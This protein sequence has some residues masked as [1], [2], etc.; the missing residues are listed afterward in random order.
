MS[1]FFEGYS[2]PRNKELMRIFR[3][4]DMVEY[5]GSGIPR[6][7]KAYPKESFRFTENFTRMIFPSA[8]PA[9]TEA[10]QKGAVESAVKS[11]VETTQ[12]TSG[13]IIQAIRNNN[14][15]TIPEMAEQFGI[16]ERSIE[17]NIQKLRESGRLLRKEGA[18]GGH[19]EILNQ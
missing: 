12:K 19:W 9:P 7:L 4:L 14:H 17:R 8:E 16:T 18:K 2:I 5:L 6:I 11:A 10:S 1:E 15:V 13:K 3:D